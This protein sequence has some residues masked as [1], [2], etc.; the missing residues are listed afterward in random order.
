MTPPL[1]FGRRTENNAAVDSVATGLGDTV[2][3]LWY[4]SLS[5]S[6]LITED[7]IVQ[8]AN[9]TNT[10]A[11]G[12]PG[13]EPDDVAVHAVVDGGARGGCRCRA[14][15][16]RCRRRAT[17]FGTR[18]A[19]GC[20]AGGGDAAGVGATPGS[21]GSGTAVPE[22]TALLMLQP[23][24]PTTVAAA[25]VRNWRRS[26]AALQGFAMNVDGVRRGLHGR[27]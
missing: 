23:A 12:E 6:S 17:G 22:V 13:V 2:P 20:T 24:A 4:G 11:L 5:V 14:T 3:T 26:T 10:G 16:P 25:R 8:M 18:P 27:H 21:A 15:L 7:Y 1:T 19:G 9:Q